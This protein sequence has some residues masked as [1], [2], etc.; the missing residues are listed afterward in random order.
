MSQDQLAKLAGVDRNTIA[1]WEYAR[2]LKPPPRDKLRAVAAALRLPL[3]WFYDESNVVTE[4]RAQ[5]NAGSATIPIPLW[6]MHSAGAWLQ[7]GSETDTFDCPPNLARHGKRIATQVQG[8]SMAPRIIEGDYLVFHL[9]PAPRFGRVHIVRNENQD[10]T[11]KIVARGSSGQIEL[12]PIN[13]AHAK[14]ASSR[15]ECIG[16]LVAILRGYDPASSRGNVE[17]DDGGIIP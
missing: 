1:N 16:Y 4:T 10:A 11:I 9:D 14:P 15:L 8:D 7:V 12:R 13:P 17:W 3:D 6:P 5:Y 2:L